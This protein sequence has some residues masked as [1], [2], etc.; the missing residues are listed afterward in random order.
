MAREHPLAARRG[1][2]LSDCLDYP[3]ALPTAH[4]GVRKTL[5]EL[6]DR[7]STTLSPMIEADSYVLLQSYVARTLSI[8][9]ELQIGAPLSATQG[10]L[11][12]RPLTHPSAAH[13]FLYIVHLKG[14]ALPVAAARF[15]AAHRR[16]LVEL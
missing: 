16:D 13:G 8:G 2:R 12:S 14:R 9:F 5:E 15:R 11:V 3:L 6:A 10:G 1:V 7:M 4:Y